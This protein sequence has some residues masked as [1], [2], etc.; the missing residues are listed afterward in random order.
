MNMKKFCLLT[1][2][3]LIT[4]IVH[5]AMIKIDGKVIDKK[6]GRVLPGANVIVE[7]TTLGTATNK[8]GKFKIDLEKGDYVIRISYSGFTSIVKTVNAKDAYLEV[9]LEESAINLEDVVVTG[10]GTQRPLKNSPVLTQVLSSEQLHNKG[11]R[12]VKDAIEYLSPSIDVSPGS[13]GANLTLNGLPNSYILI[14]ID[15]ER[16][17]G[18]VSGNTE[19][20]RLNMANVERVELLKGAA[21][22]LYGSDAIGGVIN[23]ITKRPT[24]KID[25]VTDNYLSKYSTYSTNNSI[26]FKSDKF[27]STTSFTK[28]GTDGYQLSN[29]ETSSKG[30]KETEKKIIDEAKDYTIGQRFNYTPTE[31]LSFYAK[32]SY[33]EKTKYKPEAHYKYDMGFESTTLGLGGTYHI[34]RKDFIKATYHFDNWK[35]TKDYFK[36]SGDFAEG[37]TE[38][39]KDQN[40]QELKV[41]GYF[42]WGDA[43]YLTAGAEVIGDKFKETSFFPGEESTTS[44]NLLLQDE[45]NITEDLTAVIGGRL[46]HHNEYGNYFTPQISS[47][48][49]MGDFAVRAGYSKGYKTPELKELYYDYVTSRGTHIVGNEDLDP[50]SSDYVSASVEYLTKSLNISATVFHNEVDDMI[51]NPYVPITAEDEAAGYKKRMEY[52]NISSVTTKGI[53]LLLTAKLP[54]N[55]MFKGGYSYLDATNNDTD[56]RLDGTSKHSARATLSYNNKFSD[57][58]RLS[59]ALQGKIKGDRFYE[60]EEEAPSYSLW[61]L[62]T[63]HQLFHVND[64]KFSIDLGVKNLFDYTDDRPYGSNYATIDP[65]RRVFVGLKIQFNQ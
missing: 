23:I 3:L 63:T 4:S 52:G 58:Y 5:A 38:V 40:Y 30:E 42:G 54:L 59:V 18:N 37:D 22:A 33:Y 41:I 65:G 53:D 20:D 28:K 27:S 61:N 1:A 9:A 31:Q 16:V 51:D 64:L 7:G 43:H 24:R 46:N 19:V 57:K 47:K 14:L 49:S 39:R 56:N 26:A 15:G 34:T 35:Y 45:I 2:V 50:Q 44:Y 32:G 11:F 29:L 48:Y 55:M 62:T 36:K 17:A 12:T 6:T 10:T 60:N 21:S 25:V 8:D 13:M